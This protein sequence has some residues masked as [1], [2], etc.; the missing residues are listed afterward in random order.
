MSLVTVDIESDLCKTTKRFSNDITLKEL[1]DKLY[2]VVGIAPQDMALKVY[3][4]S[5]LYL[6][7]TKVDDTNA[8][9]KPFINDDKAEIKIVVSDTNANSIANQLKDL[10]G[11]NL[12]GS[13]IKIAFQYSEQEYQQRDDSVLKWKQKNNLGR[14][15]PNYIKNKKDEVNQNQELATKLVLNERCSVKTTGQGERRGWLRFIGKISDINEVD[16]WCGI[17]FDEP[18]GKNNG[19]F[20]GTTYFGPVNDNYGGFV[21]PISVQT[22]KEFIP[23]LDDEL[24]FS[25]EEEL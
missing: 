6:N 3:S 21:K 19:V 9:L 14:F 24:D 23:L 10:E 20:K 17:E 5:E 25:D 22:G 16:T 11:E 18:V 2:L 8:S 7:V 15:D 4:R 12:D 1:C 13:D